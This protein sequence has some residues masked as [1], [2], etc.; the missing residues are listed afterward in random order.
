MKK[1][2]EEKVRQLTSQ[3]MENDEVAD[4][5]VRGTLKVFT[6]STMQSGNTQQTSLSW[7]TLYLIIKNWHR[8]N[9]A[10]Q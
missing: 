10:I 5:L 9:Q 4:A 7:L 1:I 8:K 2:F 3:K 6:H